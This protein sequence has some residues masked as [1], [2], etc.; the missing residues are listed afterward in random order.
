VQ[1]F[2]RARFEFQPGALPGKK[3]KL[4]NL[5]SHYFNLHE[6]PSRRDPIT[7]GNIVDGILNLKARAFPAAAVTKLEGKQTIYIIVKDQRRFPIANAIVTL[8]VRMPSGK[9]ISYIVPVPTNAQGVTQYS[10]NFESSEVGT[11]VIRVT[12]TYMNLK[13]QTITSFRVWW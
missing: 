7:N 3:I 1:Y 13:T 10:F 2:E 6:D 9:E 5:G 8:V 12:A 11:A 4:G